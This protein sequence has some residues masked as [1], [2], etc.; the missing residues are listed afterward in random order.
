MPRTMHSLPSTYWREK[1]FSQVVL[2][3]FQEFEL[4]IVV[5]LSRH[6]V[7]D[8]LVVLVVFVGVSSAMSLKLN[9]HYNG[10]LQK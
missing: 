10:T 8:G 1:L 3:F 9:E 4:G 5:F 2:V 7:I 6:K